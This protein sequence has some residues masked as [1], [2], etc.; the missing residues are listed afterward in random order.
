MLQKTKIKCSECG[1]EFFNLWPL[2]NG[3]CDGCLVKYFTLDDAKK[4]T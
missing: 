2:G 1:K 3:V 4:A